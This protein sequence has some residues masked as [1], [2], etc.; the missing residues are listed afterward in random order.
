MQPALIGMISIIDVVKAIMD[1]Q[2]DKIEHLE[3]N[4]S[5]GESY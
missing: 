4:I 1:E 5:W 2:K 3:H